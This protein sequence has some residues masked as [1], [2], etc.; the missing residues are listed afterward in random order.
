MKITFDSKVTLIFS[1]IAVMAYFIAR[2]F[3]DPLAQFFILNGDF[4]QNNV[5][6]Y[7]STFGYIF[8]HADT[9]HLLGNL[10]MF[11]LLAPI[12]EN[13][14]GSKQFLLMLLVTAIITAIIHTFFWDN[15]LL[16]MSGIVF[17]LIILSTLVHSKSNEIPLTFLLVLVLYLGQEILA[18]FKADNISHFAHLA[19][20][21]SGIFWAYFKK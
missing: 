10:A 9:G 2:S 16:G 14:Y 15:G 18:S 17:M 6:W 21:A 19:G 3:P 5:V 4:Q 20:G 12:I 1:A 11:L 13:K 8:G 7:A